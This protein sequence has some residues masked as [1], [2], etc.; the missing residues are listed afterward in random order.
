VLR[1]GFAVGCARRDGGV[2][3]TGSVG[4][5]SVEV[6]LKRKIEREIQNCM[7][8]LHQSKRSSRGYECFYRQ[9]FMLLCGKSR[10]ESPPSDHSGAYP[11]LQPMTTLSADSNN[12][13]SGASMFGFGISWCVLQSDGVLPLVQLDFFVHTSSESSFSIM[14]TIDTL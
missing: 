14:Q 3:C 2:A 5:V 11:R 12:H 13:N 8:F 1:S 4:G 7:L 10:L 9:V 6:E